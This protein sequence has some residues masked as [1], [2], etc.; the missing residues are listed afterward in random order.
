M[1]RPDKVDMAV[2]VDYASWGV[3]ISSRVYIHF[4]GAYIDH[5]EWLKQPTSPE[6]KKDA[7]KEMADDLQR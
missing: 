5:W 4:V 7:D 6:L 1:G 2:I 3:P